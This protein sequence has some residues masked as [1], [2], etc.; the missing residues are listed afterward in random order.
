MKNINDFPGNMKS[1]PHALAVI[2]GS[3]KY[4]HIRGQ[5]LFYK[6]HD[7][8]IVQTE[9]IGLPKGKKPCKIPFFAFH[10]HS[11]KTCTGNSK[12]PFADADGHYNPTN[13]LHPFH[14]G[15]LP[16][17]LSANGKA[18]SAVLTDRFSIAE[19]IGKT[20]IVHAMPD[21]FTTQPAGNAGEKM[22]CGVIQRTSRTNQI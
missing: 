3:E 1:E 11:G 13:C 6:T 8:V 15:D 12:D 21:D 14:A 4:P 20:I 17:L 2:R 9:I 22:A 19:I 7:G 10:I 5:V 16:P 18:Y